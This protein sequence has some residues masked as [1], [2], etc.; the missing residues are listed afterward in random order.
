MP[1]SERIT[2]SKKEKEKL[3]NSAVSLCIS[4]T[5]LR[6]LASFVTKRPIIITEKFVN[7]LSFLRNISAV[8]LFF[9]IQIDI[10][11]KM[12]CNQTLNFYAVCPASK[13]KSRVIK[14]LIISICI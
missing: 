1:I 4:K 5:F 3:S 13:L 12:F 8:P 6:V 7:Y 11:V 14:L 9:V 2:D 10:I